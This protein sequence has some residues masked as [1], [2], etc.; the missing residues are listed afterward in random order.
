LFYVLEPV[1]GSGLFELRSSAKEHSIVTHT[2]DYIVVFGGRSG[3]GTN[4]VPDV[5]AYSKDGT[6]TTMTSLPAASGLGGRFT[7]NDNAVCISGFTTS[8]WSN[9]TPQVIAY[10]NSLSRTVL[11][12]LPSGAYEIPSGS[13]AVH[14]MM[15]GGNYYG[16]TTDTYSWDINLTRTTVT[17]T[18]T[19]R[20]GAC[21]AAV[22]NYIIASGSY[23]S[24]GSS[25]PN[26][27]YDN[28]NVKT[29]LT[30]PY[31]TKIMYTKGLSTDD[32]CAFF[33][34]ASS[35]AYSAANNLIKA[36]D[37]NLVLYTATLPANGYKFSG[38]NVGGK[39][40]MLH[41]GTT[42][43]YLYNS[44]LVLEETLPFGTSSGENSGYCADSTGTFGLS[45][46][47]WGTSARMYTF[48]V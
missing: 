2:K 13:N 36:Y 41:N 21:V 45:K 38:Q 6:K 8:N 17:N 31:T 3:G 15:I 35:D 47:A 5:D 14:G 43:S 11:T 24:Y 26:D 20:I 12:S 37:K 9:R 4:P 46:T 10:N 22:G 44:D 18:S 40:M 23:Q 19:T 32:V 1:Q 34:G 30:N 7:L 42:V 39:Y 29:T 48:N 25:Y 28:S 16:A 33:G 27:A